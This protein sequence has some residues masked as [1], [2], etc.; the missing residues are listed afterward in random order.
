MTRAP[1]YTALPH[2]N[3]GLSRRPLT[4]H[5]TRFPL[6]TDCRAPCG[7]HSTRQSVVA[8]ARSYAAGLELLSQLVQRVVTLGLSS[9]LLVSFFLNDAQLHQNLVLQFLGKLGV[10][11][12]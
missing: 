9:C 12:E 11:L 3:E 8:L 5:L 1:R 10:V 4:L 2:C 6:T 7:M